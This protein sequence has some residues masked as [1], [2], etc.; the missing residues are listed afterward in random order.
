MKV[1]AVEF[2]RAFRT[3][4]LKGNVID[5]SVAV[6]VGGAFGKIVTSLVSDVIMP[7]V[8]PL[9]PGGDWRQT[10]VGTG[11]KIG[12][13]L[14]TLVDFVVIATV[15]FLVIRGFERFKKREEALAAPVAI[16]SDPKVEAE[17]RFIEALNNFSRKCL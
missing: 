14:G 17:T 6:I 11:I 13:F 16:V 3:F 2:L 9:I 1:D 7:L 15:L 8:N 10:T 12:M 4:A 5:L